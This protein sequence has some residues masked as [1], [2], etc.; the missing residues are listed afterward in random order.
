MRTINIA[1]EKKRDAAVSFDIIKTKRRVEFFLADGSPRKNIKILK[2][3]I[4]QDLPALLQKYGS[5]EN[6]TDELIKGDPEV[7]LEH[8]GLMLE[9]T[10][11]IYVTQDNQ[12]LYG[13]DLYEIIH[14]PDGSEKE[15]QYYTPKLSNINKELPILCTGKKFPKAQA[16]K[17]FIFSRK[18]QIK[19]INGLTYDFLYE[20][21]KD[22]DTTQ[23][24]MLVGG[25]K[26]GAEPLIMRDGGTPYRGFLEGRVNGDKYCL[27]LHLTNLELKEVTG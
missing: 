22:L 11:R 24:M 8:T 2:C 3:T 1:N 7:D 12:L 10:R 25:G 9:D 4:D 21:A 19:H 13:V 23:T 26:N 20:I 6:V 27:I 5:L 18:Y 17:R 16:V 14:N 15:R